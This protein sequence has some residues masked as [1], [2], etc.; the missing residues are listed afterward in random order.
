M[1][2]SSIVTSVFKPYGKDQYIGVIAN[3]EKGA[4]KLNSYIKTDDC[5]HYIFGLID[6]QIPVVI[7]TNTNIIADIELLDKIENEQQTDNKENGVGEGF[8]Y[9]VIDPVDYIRPIS[10]YDGIYVCHR[11]L[12]FEEIKR[13]LL[14][15][16]Y[17]VDSYKEYAEQ[18]SSSDAWDLF[19]LYHFLSG[20]NDYNHVKED[21][22]AKPVNQDDKKFI[23]WQTI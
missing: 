17:F 22:F 8:T 23:D 15:L 13:F 21:F 4:F 1:E 3:N 20:Q 2:Q 19:A 6:N 7:T 11:Q 16:P 12:W 18:T 5:S 14:N 9:H 10:V